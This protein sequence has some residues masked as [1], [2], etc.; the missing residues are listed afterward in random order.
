MAVSPQPQSSP[1]E[2]GI[3]FPPPPGHRRSTGQP[4]ALPGADPP[5]TLPALLPASPPRQRR[6]RLSSLP[7]RRAERR[8]GSGQRTP[9]GL[10]C[11]ADGSARGQ[12]QRFSGFQKP[13]LRRLCPARHQQ[14][15][16]AQRGRHSARLPHGPTAPQPHRHLP[17]SRAL[18]VTRRSPHRSLL[19]ICPHLGA[20]P[21]PPPAK[22]IAEPYTRWLLSAHR[23]SGP[24]PGSETIP[25]PPPPTLLL[26]R[27]HLACTVTLVI[28][29][30]SRAGLGLAACH[31]G[32]LPPSPTQPGPSCFYSFVFL[33]FSEEQSGARALLCTSGSPRDHDDPES[34]WVPLRP[35]SPFPSYQ[36]VPR[37]LSPPP[38]EPNLGRG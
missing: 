29:D 35:D 11:G 14:A 26:N 24:L 13:E 1:R 3:P 6:A 2:G 34:Q 36:G 5:I 7:R 12:R 19:V 38:A 17:H 28:R 22:A 33:H 30:P 18:S 32:I 37:A 31:G 16:V 23:G 9:A 25:T 21:H 27:I 4:N 15:H 8:R 10:R 20:A